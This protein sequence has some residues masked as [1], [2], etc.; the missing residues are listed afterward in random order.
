VRIGVDFDNTIVSYDTL[1]HR[2]A[3]ERSLIPSDLP[4]T[5]LSVREY[6]RQAGKED[7]WTEMQG[8][9]Y[10]ARMDDAVAYP[11]AIDFFAWA[12]S[13]NMDLAI[14]SHKTRRPILGHPYD[15]HEAAR[16]WVAKILIDRPGPLIDEADVHFELTKE[17]KLARISALG[18]DFFID[19]L[20]EILL[21]DAFPDRTARI[22]FDPDGTYAGNELPALLSWDDIKKYFQDKWTKRN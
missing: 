19:D 8:Y 7:A 15:L 6:L 5:K 17:A 16:R 18:L 1:F 10:G 11:G 13:A 21:A 9:V 22:L 2:V 12:R 3:L 20:P 4:S 14:V